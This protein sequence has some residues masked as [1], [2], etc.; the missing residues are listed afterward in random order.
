MKI[1]DVIFFATVA[2]S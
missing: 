2:R 1:K